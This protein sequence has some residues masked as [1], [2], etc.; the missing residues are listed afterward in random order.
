MRL[1]DLRIKYKAM[2]LMGVTV[3]TAGTMFTVATVGLSKIKESL[4]ELLL[5]TN[6]ERYAYET[7]L[8]EKNYLLNANGST[9][10][11]D[12]AAEAF[13]TAEKDVG[14][15][16]QTLDKIDA[17]DNASLKEKSKAARVGTQ[18]YADLYRKG[19]AALT[20]LSGLTKSLEVD[21]QTAT[22]QARAYIRAMANADKKQIATEILEFTYLIRANEKRYMLTQKPA[23]FE[24]MKD[25]FAKMMQLL[26]KLESA[27]STEVER[28]QVQ[29]FKK[30]SLAYEQAAHNWVKNNN[31][32]FKDILP[33]MK[34]LGDE[35]IRLADDAAKDASAVMA[36]TRDGIITMLIIIALAIVAGGIALGLFVANMISRPIIGLTA[37]M[38]TL[39]HGDTNVEVP[40]TKQQDEIG[41][42]ARSVQVFK[43]NEIARQEM[44]AK[45]KE[46]ARM[47]L[48]ME[49]KEKEREQQEKI[50]NQ[51]KAQRAEKVATLVRDFETMIRSVVGTLA[52]SATD[53]QTN[54]TSMSANAQQTQKQSAAVAAASQQATANAQTAASATEEMASSSAEIGQQI[55]R[56]S[57]IAREAV[58]QAEQTGQTVDELAKTAQN[59][60][61]VV[62]LIQQIAAQTNLLALN[63]T[64]E[65]ARA[66]EAGKGFAVVAQEVK[67]LAGQTAKATEQINQ[68]ING[69]QGATVSTVNAIKGIG[70][71]IREISETSAAVAAAV[72]EQVAAAGEVA[73][74]VQQAAKGTEDIS[75]NISGVARAADQTGTASESVL[76]IAGQLSQQSDTLRGEVDKFLAALNAA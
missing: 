72:Q 18:K 15:I 30:A 14:I 16:N 13:K 19:V 39:A 40:S 46:N 75:A 56:A 41:V 38:E 33:Q 28:N 49:A 32:L 8:Q 7:I 27:A 22:D 31:A 57:Q 21:G 68:Q 71:T 67:A 45:E 20:D 11:E 36:S 52:S 24:E 6:V 54:A 17:S 51:H 73:S 66:G 76:A 44:E 23:V 64:I 61:A 58:D 1:S 65:A 25:E 2:I 59:I 3:V 37:T 50:E 5:S 74:N 35:V 4:D 53:M 70:A 12:L 42:M 47:R 63:A 48:E 26:A 10:R 60:G 9:A 62:E 34:T 69:M 55:D 29:T 43:D